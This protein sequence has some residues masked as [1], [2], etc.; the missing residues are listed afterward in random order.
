MTHEEMKERAFDILRGSMEYN[1]ITDYELKK[2][3][4]AAGETVLAAFIEEYDE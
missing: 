4:D 2:N 3:I 1:H